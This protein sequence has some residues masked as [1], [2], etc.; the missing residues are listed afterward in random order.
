MLEVVECSQCYSQLA[1]GTHHL[2]NLGFPLVLQAPLQ[3]L[4][5]PPLLFLWE[6]HQNIPWGSHPPG[7]N[8]NQCQCPPKCEICHSSSF[9]TPAEAGTDPG[10]L[11]QVSDLEHVTV[12]DWIWHQ[13]RE[14]SIPAALFLGSATALPPGKK[15]ERWD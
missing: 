12:S 10:C 5:P 15:A 11:F 8:S 7:L 13:D 14:F 3:V 9:S 2:D 4:L 1:E 6:Q